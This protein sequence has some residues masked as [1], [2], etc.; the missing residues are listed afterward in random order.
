MA[1]ETGAVYAMLIH[2]DQYQV[3]ARLR[4]RLEERLE[5]R[6]RTEDLDL[7]QSYLRRYCESERI[8]CLDLLPMLSAAPDPESLYLR[9]DTH[10][11][12]AGNARGG[13]EVASFVERTLLA[14]GSK[15][16]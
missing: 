15:N 10:D 4:R 2:P 9:N 12:R 13:E 14:D 6:V 11:K 3:D 1:D 5:V 16:P 8:A 7:P